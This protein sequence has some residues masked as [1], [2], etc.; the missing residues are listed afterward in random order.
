VPGRREVPVVV[1]TQFLVAP[2]P[3]D[4]GDPA[5]VFPDV[6]LHLARPN[7]VWGALE[8]SPL[9]VLS[10]AGDWAYVP[11]HWKSVGDEDPSLGIPTTYYAAAQLVGE[12]E[13]VDDAAAKLDLLRR[14]L[15]ALEPDVAHADPAVHR[16]KL[17]GI[18]GIRI[19]VRDVTAKFKYGGN[20]DAEHRQAIAERLAQRDGPGDRAARTHLLRRS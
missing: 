8:E 14:Q 19:R 20:V 12:A 16:R 18:R 3:S 17:A 4:V 7:P 2:A 5:A 9:V 10:V 13:V 15:A 11:S 1:P 6:W